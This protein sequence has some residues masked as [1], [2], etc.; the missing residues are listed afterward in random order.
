MIIWNEIKDKLKCE[1]HADNDCIICPKSHCSECKYE[2]DRRYKIFNKEKIRLFQK[3]DYH[4]NKRDPYK[5]KKMLE[6]S[7]KRSAKYR[8]NKKIKIQAIVE[9][10]DKKKK[11]IEAYI[12]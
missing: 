6:S 12:K 7:R 9:K 2:N 5:Y 11:N 3:E 1:K 10:I 8:K 4:K